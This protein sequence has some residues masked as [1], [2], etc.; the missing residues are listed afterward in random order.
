MRYYEIRFQGERPVYPTE[1][2]CC[3]ADA[4][5]T[6]DT[7]WVDQ[8][9]RGQPLNHEQIPAC[10]VC[11]KHLRAADPSFLIG[12]IMLWFIVWI[13]LIRYAP[14]WNVFVMVPIFAI[15]AMLTIA[16]CLRKIRG[17]KTPEGH[18]R[19]WAALASYDRDIITLKFGREMYAR[20][21]ALLNKERIVACNDALSQPLPIDLD[22]S[23]LERD[24]AVIGSHA[25]CDLVVPQLASSAFSI[26]WTPAG[27]WLEPIE[28][29]P[30]ISGAPSSRGY[31]LDGDFIGAGDKY[32]QV[33]IPAMKHESAGMRKM[34][35]VQRLER[36]DILHPLRKV[37]EGVMAD[38]MLKALDVLSAP[39]K[40]APPPHVAPS[41][42]PSS[43]RCDEYARVVSMSEEFLHP[44]DRSLFNATASDGPGSVG[45]KCIYCNRRWIVG[46]DQGNDQK[47]IYRWREVKAPFCRCKDYEH[48]TFRNHEFLWDDDQASFRVLPEESSYI[49]RYE[50]VVCGRRWNVQ[51]DTPRH[52]DFYSWSEAKPP[53]PTSAGPRCVC[54]DYAK[55]RVYSTFEFASDVDRMSFKA[56]TESNDSMRKYECVVCGRQWSVKIKSPGSQELYRW[57]E[58]RR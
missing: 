54:D 15:T 51:I 25:S 26:R 28:L 3:G 40:P 21:F 16:W 38:E 35:M 27:H 48:Q 13:A 5:T 45:W 9:Y 7:E 55:L 43:C 8:P 46:S 6:F 10:A 47:K 17:M 50:C 37:D 18:A 24:I 53:S 39:P 52:E 22:G 34:K 14:R 56:L 4:T 42:P 29:T 12:K 44:N 11:A 58:M 30:E 49:H 23:V 32:L 41:P 33:R 57:R 19:P 31:L 2:C 20:Y 36:L 1:C